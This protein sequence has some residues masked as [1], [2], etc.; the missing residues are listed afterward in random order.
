M[1]PIEP[2]GATKRAGEDIARILAAEAGTS[3]VIGRVFNLIGPGLQDRHLPGKLA[4]Q[5]SAIARGLAPPEPRW[6]RSTPHATSST[7]ATP[8]PRC[9]RW[10]PHRIRLRP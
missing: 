2:Y 3:L 5:I 8:P 4:S 10:P 6:A 7:P 9:W 1:E